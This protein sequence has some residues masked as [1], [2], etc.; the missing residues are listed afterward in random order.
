M[1]KSLCVQLLS[2]PLTGYAKRITIN[3]DAA[4]IIIGPGG[5][6]Y[7]SG[8]VTAEKAVDLCYDYENTICWV[9]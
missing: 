9:Y 8:A 7:A 2:L 6:K 3:K 5:E 4:G 1:D